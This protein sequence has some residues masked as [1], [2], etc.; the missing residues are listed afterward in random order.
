MKN[1]FRLENEKNFN[2]DLSQNRN[3]PQAIEQLE[4]FDDLW[5]V[6]KVELLLVMG[7]FKKATEIEFESKEWYDGK[8]AK[9]I[10]SKTLEDFEDLLKNM[11][12]EFE[13]KA[14]VAKSNVAH[15]E[16]NYEFVRNVERAIYYVARDRKEIGRLIEATEKGDDRA[17]GEIYGFPGTCIDAYAKK[18]E[19]IKVSEL[20]EEVR[21]MAET[22]FANF[23]LSRDHW[24]DEME[25]LKKWSEYVRQ[26]SPKIHTENV[27]TMQEVF[28]NDRENENKN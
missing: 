12:L 23:R 24:K 21:G 7:G 8:D 14:E 19:F 4:R 6:K 1:G 17:M 11:G 16:D 27:R 18:G 26:M 10:S 9:K 15:E 2:P 28:K 3:L 5:V 20:P 25:T 22:A 13:K